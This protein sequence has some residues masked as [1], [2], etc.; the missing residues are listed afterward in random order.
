MFKRATVR[1]VVYVI[2]L[3]AMV[4]AV[5]SMISPTTTALAVS[6]MVGCSGSNQTLQGISAIHSNGALLFSRDDV[7]RVSANGPFNVNQAQSTS[8]CAHR[9]HYSALDPKLAARAL[10]Q[11]ESLWKAGAISPEDYQRAKM[12]FAPARQSSRPGA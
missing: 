6:V 12:Q 1:R 10:E 2:A 7:V 3:A 8:S 9:W 11:L 5:F 4:L